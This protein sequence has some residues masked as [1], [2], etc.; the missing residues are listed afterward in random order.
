MLWFTA[1][2][3]FGQEEA[4]CYFIRPFQTVREMDEELIRRHNKIVAPRDTVY[5]L[6]DLT[7]FGQWQQSY[8]T[9][10]VKALHGNKVL[11]LGNH[12]NFNPFDYVKMGFESVHTELKIRGFVLVHDP[13]M[14]SGEGHVLC[15]HVHRLFKWK[16]NAINVGV[17]VWDYEPVSYDTILA[18]ANDKTKPVEQTGLLF[19]RD[20]VV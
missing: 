14:L 9:Q 1:D 15:G 3:H 8:V 5:F 2:H 4:M 7:L 12:D 11:I 19:D 6:G 13:M 20:S 10:T 17:D 16:G 18:L